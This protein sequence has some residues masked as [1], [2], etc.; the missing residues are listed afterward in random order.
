MKIWGLNSHREMFD[1]TPEETIIR[2]EANYGL[3]V[4]PPAIKN[5]PSV[6]RALLNGA[7]TADNIAWARH[8]CGDFAS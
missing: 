5:S 7:Y 1:R 3:S 2:N 4:F 8:I 6:A